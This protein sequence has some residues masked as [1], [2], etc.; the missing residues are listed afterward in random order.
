MEPMDSKMELLNTI[1]I[2]MNLHYLTDQLPMPNYD[3]LETSLSNQ[4]DF[5]RSGSKGRRE[6]RK[7]SK[8]PSYH[9]DHME[10]TSNRKPSLEP[11]NISLKILLTIFSKKKKIFQKSKE[12]ISRHNRIKPKEGKPNTRPKQAP[13]PKEKI[14]QTI[15]SK[16]IPYKFQS[17]KR[18]TSK[19]SKTA[20]SVE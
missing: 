14:K 15:P 17:K 18:N 19:S 2:P 6:L 9:D 4:T 12:Q 1:K 3:P 20:K 13:N 16:K 7:R 10:S 8:S 5:V 11:S